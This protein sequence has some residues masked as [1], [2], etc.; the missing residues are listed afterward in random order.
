MPNEFSINKKIEAKI[1]RLISQLISLKR[2]NDPR[3][4]EVIINEV[5]VNKDI[6]TARIYFVVL[7]SNYKNN[8]EPYELLLKKT[9]GFIKK[10]IGSQ[11]RLKK[12]PDLIFKYD[13]KEEDASYLNDLINKAIEI[14]QS[15]K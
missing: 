6:S 4:S 3:L 12:I 5:K 1:Q 9:S 10:E 11:L 15:Q 7:N 13:T 2:I 8:N 14:D